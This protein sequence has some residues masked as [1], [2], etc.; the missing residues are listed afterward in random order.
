MELIIE[1]AALRSDLL[2][3]KHILCFSVSNFISMFVVRREG[4]SFVDVVALRASVEM[5]GVVRRPTWNLIKWN[6]VCCVREGHFVDLRPLSANAKLGQQ[7]EEVSAELGGE[8]GVQVW[9][10]TRV[11]GVEEDQQDL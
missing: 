2:S 8:N 5:V 6:G 3:D 4:L 10:G 11:D 1:L 9:I 7:Q